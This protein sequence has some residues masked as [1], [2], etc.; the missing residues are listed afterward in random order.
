MKD[1]NQVLREFALRSISD[2][3]E[4]LETIIADILS[5]T[6][7]TTV[8]PTRETVLAALS[9]LIQH[10]YA[11]AYRFEPPFREAKQERYTPERADDLWFYVTPEGKRLASDLQDEWI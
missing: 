9:E 1:T 3:Y 8:E 7:G 10:G 2:D 4:N 5:W 11:Q 6:V